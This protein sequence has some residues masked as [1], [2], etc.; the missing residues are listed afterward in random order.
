MSENILHQC[1]DNKQ[2]AHTHAHTQ[3][4]LG[5]PLRPWSAARGRGRRYGFM[6]VP[7]DHIWN[8]GR[9][10]CS[11]RPNMFI[12]F[13]SESTSKSSN[14][15]V[16]GHVHFTPDLFV[17]NA[18][19]NW[20]IPQSHRIHQPGLI[21]SLECIV[22]SNTHEKVVCAVVIRHNWNISNSHANMPI[23]HWQAIK[24]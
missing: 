12:S 17:S 11:C 15:S 2:F 21:K 23:G 14:V 8:G 7:S 5:V 6:S 24:W 22:Q 10:A 20:L 18:I 4:W 9:R 3:F 16:F 19:L 1:F 13:S